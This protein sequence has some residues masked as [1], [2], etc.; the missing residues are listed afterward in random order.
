[1]IYS[2]FLIILSLMMVWA[3]PAV[4][5]DFLVADLDE[6]RVNIATNFQGADL[7]LFGTLSNEL[8]DDIIIT[9][10]GPLKPV[11][12]RKKD[13]VA[14]IWVNKESILLLEVPSFYQLSSTRLPNVIASS[15][16]LNNLQVGLKNIPLKID[17]TAPLSKPV[18]AIWNNALIRNMQQ[19]GL[20][21][22]NADIKI[23]QQILFRANIHLPAN[24]LPGHYTVRIL[25]FRSGMLINE[26]LST[27]N[28]KKSGLSAGIFNFAHQY[29]PLYGI[30][31]IIFAV[32]AGWGAAA[33]FRR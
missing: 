1:M 20:W 29:A 12:L 3:V 25:Q 22:E 26:T 19:S 33:L 6:K 8:S 16:V 18:Q 17:A 13:Q 15:Q 23:H 4:S 5:V 14:G 9:V 11:A 30:F 2:R 28:V 27:I 31:A 21:N 7:L 24:V 32:S 10:E